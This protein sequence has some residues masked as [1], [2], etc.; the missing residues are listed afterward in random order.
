MLNNHR[1]KSIQST[2]S[3]KAQELLS[4]GQS[5][6]TIDHEQELSEIKNQ[7]KNLTPS[8]Q[9]SLQTLIKNSKLESEIKLP[10]R[11]ALLAQITAYSYLS[12]EKRPYQVWDFYLEPHYNSIFHCIYLNH[13]D[14]ICIVA[15]RGTD[16]KNKS[17]LISDAQII[18]WVNAIDPRVIGSLELFDQL[19]KTHGNYQ[20]WICWHSLGGT[21]CYIVAK[22]R[23]VDYCCTFNPW[24]APN[25]IFILMLKDT[26]LKSNRTSKIHTYKIL[27]DPVSLCSYVGE[28]VSFFVPSMSVMKLHSMDNFFKV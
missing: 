4:R 5:A 22:H 8:T 12:P 1:R 9:D 25:K 11:D 17:D 18:L 27:G 10:E 23:D 13:K 14:K 6:L 7:I 19:R 15:Y 26:L 3:Q 24:S 21:L 16:F 20:K 28:T 2:I